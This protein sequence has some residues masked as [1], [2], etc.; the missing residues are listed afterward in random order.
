MRY[1]TRALCHRPARGSHIRAEEKVFQRPS[2]FSYLPVSS[3]PTFCFA[4]PPSNQKQL[5]SRMWLLSPIDIVISATRPSKVY[6]FSQR[7]YFFSLFPKQRFREEK[8]VSTREVSDRET[9]ISTWGFHRVWMVVGCLL[10]F[11]PAS[12]RVWTSP[13][14]A[15][16]AFSCILFG[17]VTHTKQAGVSTTRGC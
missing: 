5:S 15:G 7:D 4:L 8:G 3:F 2:S 13:W 9:S 10:R 17:V 14:R 1:S 16:C 6:T 11:P 12:T